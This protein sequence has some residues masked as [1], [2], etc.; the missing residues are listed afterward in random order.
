M[1]ALHAGFWGWT[2]T[3]SLTPLSHRFRF[4][5]PDVI[6]PELQ[7]DDVSPVI[8]VADRGWQQLPERSPRLAA[9][10]ASIHAD[11]E[12]LAGALRTLPQTFLPGDWKMGNLG[13]RADGRT[14]LL[15]CAYPGDGPGCWDLAWYLALNQARLPISK[16]DTI[17]WYRRSLEANG[18][19]TAGWF[20]TQI[21]LSLLGMIACFGWEKALGSDEELAWW[22][23]RALAAARRLAP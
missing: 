1:A 9:L 23:D 12:L 21:D 15:D 19:A 6:A 20:E 16:E 17:A 18:I 7:R 11:P 4:F 5:A 8:E 14:I 22:E 3:L 10:I 2:D 13:R